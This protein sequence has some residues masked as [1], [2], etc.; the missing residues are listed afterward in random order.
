MRSPRLIWGSRL[1]QSSACPLVSRRSLVKAGLLGAGSFSLAHLLRSQAVARESISSQTSARD[2]SIIFLWLWG[3]PSHMETFDMKPGAPVE[4]RGEFRPIATSVPG[5]EICEHLPRLAPLA[6]KFSLIRSLSH[7]SP[8]H[9]N[10]THTLMTSYPGALAEAPPF[11]PQY[12]DFNSVASRL[13]GPRRPGTPS[14]VAMPQLRYGGSAYL[15]TGLNPLSVQADPNAADFRVPALGIDADTLRTLEDRRSLQQSLDGFQRQWDQ[16]GT[17]SALDQFEQQAVQMLANQQVRDAFRLEREPEFLRERYGRHLVGQRCLLARRLVEAGVRMV[18]VDFPCVPGQKAFSWDDHASVWNIFDEMKTRLP[19]LDQVVSAL[20]EDLDGRGLLNDVLLVVMGEM[21][22][23]P[24]INIHQGNPGREHWAH[25]M[26]LLMAGGGLPMGQVVGSTS[27]RGDEPKDRPL[28]P[29]DL[30][31]TWY[32]YLGI[33][34]ET[35]FPDHFGRPT[36][37]L[38]QGTPI[39]EFFP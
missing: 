16:S 32:R 6:D 35:T 14:H 20:I 28:V 4:Y 30:L 37:I 9:V 17:M 11:E 1:A 39:R 29:G 19:V 34:T 36:P 21:S 10:S 7:S 38:A 23:T 3:G 2:K 24:R 15:G 8:G 33:S 31:A 18:T 27:S 26:S 12:P 22:H 13:V 25:T 5:I